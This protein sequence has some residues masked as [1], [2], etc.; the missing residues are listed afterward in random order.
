MTEISVALI[1]LLGVIFSAVISYLISK[2]A[3][4]NEIKK[5]QLDITKTYESKI[6]ESRLESYPQLY[7]I[8]SDLAKKVRTS[9]ITKEVFEQALT[10]IEDWDSKNAIFMS[11]AT[12]SV[13]FE[14]R[15]YL[16][17]LMKEMT[18]ETLQKT[19]SDLVDEV[20]IFEYA[21]KNDLGI[22]GVKGEKIYEMKEISSREE[23]LE[24]SRKLRKIDSAKII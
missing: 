24:E 11:A 7:F 17:K 23:F 19:T 8:L 5:L 18:E 12:T 3:I 22:W 10:D 1:V 21:L 4:K 9:K 20:G 16:D 14:F 15:I 6:L 13:C 2:N